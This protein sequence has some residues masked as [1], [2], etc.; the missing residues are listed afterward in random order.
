[1]G[2]AST[3]SIFEGTK[4]FITKSVTGTRNFISKSMA[5]ITK[6][7]PGTPKVDA[8][9][10]DKTPKKTAKPNTR[11]SLIKETKILYLACLDIWYK[12]YNNDN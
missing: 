10:L 2:F 1:M 6:L 5:G 9:D 4:N 7:L 12:I 8:D 11:E 3:K